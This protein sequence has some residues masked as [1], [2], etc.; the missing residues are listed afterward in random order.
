MT[1]TYNIKFYDGIYGDLSFSRDDFSK[2]VIEKDIADIS[3]ATIYTEIIEWIHE[4][5]RVEIE[6][7]DEIIFSW[8]VKEPR[9]E[10]NTMEIQIVGFKSLLQRKFITADITTTSFD[11]LISSIISQWLSISWETLTVERD[12]EFVIKNETRS[13]WSTIYSVLDSV[14]SDKYAFDFDI[15]RKKIKVKKTLGKTVDRLYTYSPY[16][17]DNNIVSVRMVENENLRNLSINFDTLAITPIENLPSSK[18]GVLAKESRGE[19]Y[20]WVTREYEMSI[21]DDSLSAGDSLTIEVIGNSYIEYYGE[22]YVVRETITIEKWW[23][24]KE[25]EINTIIKKRKTITQTVLDLM[26]K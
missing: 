20:V 21:M 24:S 14:C 1:R 13:K 16:H 2:I 25:V 23:M 4:L 9:V 11:Y 26:R 8:F 18:Y 15:L 10:E 3:V 7:D 5:D 12:E 22:A 6:Q 17:L 19:D